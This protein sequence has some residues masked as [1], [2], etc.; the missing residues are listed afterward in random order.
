[1]SG[2]YLL[3]RIVLVLLAVVWL[4]A[5]VRISVPDACT[6]P[7]VHVVAFLVVVLLPLMVVSRIEEES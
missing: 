1:M 4:V 6:N 7:L 5:F 2:R 3:R